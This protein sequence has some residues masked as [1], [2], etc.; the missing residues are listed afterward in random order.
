M[1]ALFQ[2]TGVEVHDHETGLNFRRLDLLAAI[3]WVYG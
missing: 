2:K 3:D 1:M